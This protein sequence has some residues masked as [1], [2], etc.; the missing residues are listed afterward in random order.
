[1]A[2][3]SKHLQ[4]FLAGEALDG[5]FAPESLGAV[6]ECFLMNELDRGLIL[7]IKSAFFRVVLFEAAGNISGDAGIK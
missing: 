6:E 4:L 3:N 2:G 7:G 5:V 1:M